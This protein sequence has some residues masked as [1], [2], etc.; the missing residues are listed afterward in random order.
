MP[1]PGQEQVEALPKP[2]IN[3]WARVGHGSGTGRV[4]RV[5]FKSGARWAIL[6]VWKGGMANTDQY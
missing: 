3:H 5:E 1:G 6:V 2:R 4:G